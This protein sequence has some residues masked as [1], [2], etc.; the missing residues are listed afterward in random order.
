MASIVMAQFRR[1]ATRP[2]ESSRPTWMARYSPG[3]ATVHD[4]PES[5][6]TGRPCALAKTYFW[7][8]KKTILARKILFLARKPPIFGTNT[9]YFWHA[10]P[11][12]PSVRS[13][14]LTPG[15]KR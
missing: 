10:G 3:G 14:Q 11:K 6:T 7:H 8:E 15:I 9:P 5:K 13:R 2:S 4:A 12:H 1:C